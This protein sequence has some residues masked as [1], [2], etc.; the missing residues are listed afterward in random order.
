[1]ASQR[2]VSFLPAATEMV[3]ALGCGDRLV[4]ITHECDYPPSVKSKSVVATGAAAKAEEI[5]SQNALRLK[6]MKQITDSLKRRPRVA[7]MEWIEPA[8]SGGH[9]V[10]EMVESAGGID[11]FGQKGAD[12]ARIPWEEILK[13][14]PEFLIVSPCGFNLRQSLPHI[15]QLFQKP[16]WSEIPAVRNGNVYAVDA[17]AYFARPGTRI[18]DGIELLIHLFYPDRFE[19]HGPKE[20]FCKIESNVRAIR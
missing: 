4:G 10:P 6:K 14:E 1:M 16:G 8:Y 13:A 9:W 5:I 20:A 7:F 3:Y 19:W 2:I 18:I 15:P 17:N 12:S 11:L